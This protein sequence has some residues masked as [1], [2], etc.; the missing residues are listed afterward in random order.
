MVHGDIR[1]TNLLVRVDERGF[2]IL[3]FDWTGR[4]GVV[5]Y[6]I[7]VNHDGIS[8]PLTASDGELVKVEHDLAMVDFMIRA[9]N[10]NYPSSEF[11]LFLFD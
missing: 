9:S 11:C 5:W 7:N 3:D 10:C 8:R 4:V 2:K 1:G 6:P